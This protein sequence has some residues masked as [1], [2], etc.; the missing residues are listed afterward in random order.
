MLEINIRGVRVRFAFG[1]FAVLLVYFYL[2]GGGQVE[3][4]LVCCLLHELGHLA[5]ML[6]VGCKPLA[7]TFY[8][9]GVSI[10]AGDMSLCGRGAQ[11]FILLAGAAVNFLLSGISHRIGCDG[12]C[13]INMALGLLNLLPLPIF[14]GGR[15]L[16][17]FFSKR[18]VILINIFIAA[19]AAVSF[20]GGAG[21][22]TPLPIVPAVFVF[23]AAAGRLLE[24]P[25]KK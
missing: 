2:S 13:E 4:A 12:L 16:A 9:G 24:S 21:L 14:D 22:T 18:T 25:V 15:V 8:A 19:A 11:T 20:A 17:L 7:V 5:A 3:A 6:A 1:F 10:S 23:S